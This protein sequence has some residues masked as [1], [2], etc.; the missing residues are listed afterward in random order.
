M[1]H[2]V[3]TI[4]TWSVREISDKTLRHSF[5]IPMIQSLTPKIEKF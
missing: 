5:L 4:H 3:S 2:S 1:A